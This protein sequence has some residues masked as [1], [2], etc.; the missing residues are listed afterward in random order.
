MKGKKALDV[1]DIIIN[2]LTRAG[3]LV[4]LR[5]VC[6]KARGTSGSSLQQNS[7]LWWSDQYPESKWI[8]CLRSMTT[9]YIHNPR[10]V[11]IQI[12]HS[13]SGAAWGNGDVLTDWKR[14]A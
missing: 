1:L 5:N 14:A 10:V 6:S 11:A 8:D 12:R 4:I 3:L 2:G 9:R 13:I 7:N